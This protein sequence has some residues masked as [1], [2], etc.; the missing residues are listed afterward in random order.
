MKVAV[1]KHIIDGD[2]PPI[3]MVMS[4][5]IEKYGAQSVFGRPLYARELLRMVAC[6]NIERII[7]DGKQAPNMAVWAKEHP[8]DAKI[9]RDVELLVNKV[10]PR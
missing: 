4:G 9:F 5:W 8:E 10:E 3:E 6:A 1:Y 7:K 2:R